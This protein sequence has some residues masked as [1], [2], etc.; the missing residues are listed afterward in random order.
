MP[1]PKV[2]PSEAGSRASSAA[3]RP[4]TN[5]SS[6]VVPTGKCGLTCRRSRQAPRRPLGKRAPVR[7]RP[8]G[9]APGASWW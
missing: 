8:S 4:C 6:Y 7:Y 2:S 5:I 9:F 1:V 3:R